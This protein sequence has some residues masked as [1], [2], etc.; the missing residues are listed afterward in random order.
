MSADV[1]HPQAYVALGLNGLLKVGMSKDAK[2]RASS[3]RTVF[4]TKGDTFHRIHICPRIEAA[5]SV[6]SS[7][8]R[9]CEEKYESHSGREWFTSGDFE[10]VVIEAGRLT[11]EW[12]AHRYPKF[13]E[14]RLAAL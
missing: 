9:F 12:K 4:K 14:A 3:L 7:L 10:A 11:E 6:E 13:T 1:I 2:T 8:I 5:Y